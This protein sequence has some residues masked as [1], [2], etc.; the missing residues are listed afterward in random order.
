MPNTMGANLR[1]DVS[2]ISVD[3]REI[4]HIFLGTLLASQM[5]CSS[6]KCMIL[7]NGT[8]LEMEMKKLSSDTRFSANDEVTTER[9]SMKHQI[10]NF[11]QISSFLFV[12]VCVRELCWWYFA[13]SGNRSFLQ[14][15]HSPHWSST[16]SLVNQ[17][18]IIVR[19]STFCSPGTKKRR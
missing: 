19:D 14:T 8:S 1:T 10:P 13:F 9:W 18:E 2:N 17:T 15:F 11:Y 6:G 4:C 5:R 16:C 3:G 7:T 12:C